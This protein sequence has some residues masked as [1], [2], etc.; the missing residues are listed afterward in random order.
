MVPYVRNRS[1]EFG[2]EMSSVINA[3][4]AH[5]GTYGHTDDELVTAHYSDNVDEMSMPYTEP[6]TIPEP[7]TYSTYDGF[8]SLGNKG[9]LTIDDIVKGLSRETPAPAPRAVPEQK[10]ETGFVMPGQEAPARAA[11]PSAPISADVAAFVSAIVSGNRDAAF[12]MLRDT[13]RGG[14]DAEAFLTQVACA[15]DDAYRA[16]LEGTPVHPEVKRVT[17]P[18]A[19]NVLERL[20]TAFTTAVDSSYSVGITG[21]KLAL[22]RALATLGA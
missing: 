14:G 21:A 16:R 13:I 15:I 10:T 20:V 22:T 6:I 3:D 1:L 11:A 7:R 19:T 9:A 18:V 8:S 5:R 17:D 2:H 12:G 4:I